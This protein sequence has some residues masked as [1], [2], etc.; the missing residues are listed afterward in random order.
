MDFDRIH[1]KIVVIESNLSK[2]KVLSKEPLD[3]FLSDFRNIESAKYLLLVSIECMI[4]ICEHIVAKKRLGIP[5]SSAECIRFVFTSGYVS[6][7]NMES[8]ITMTKFR[9]R[10]VHLYH[11]VDD[12]ELFSIIQNNLQDFSS[13]IKEIVIGFCS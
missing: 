8:Y 1:R 9:N 13:F 3:V 6:K 10:I 2:L 7:D 5:D 11:E 4:D 12:E